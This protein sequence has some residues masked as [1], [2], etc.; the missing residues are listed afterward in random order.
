MVSPYKKNVH[1]NNPKHYIGDLLHLNPSQDRWILSQ[2]IGPSQLACRSTACGLNAWCS[3]IGGQL[4]LVGDF[5]FAMWDPNS[6]RVCINSLNLHKEEIGLH[7]CSQL[8]NSNTLIMQ[9]VTVK[10]QFDYVCKSSGY[11]S[12][13]SL[14]WI[15]HQKIVKRISFCFIS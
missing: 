13:S 12:V 1:L 2:T 5:E 4:W 9:I 15:I 7:C 10:E 6:W 14:K 8:S 3:N 11:R